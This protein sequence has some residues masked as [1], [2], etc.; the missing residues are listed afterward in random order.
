MGSALERQEGAGTVTFGLFYWNEMTHLS[1][2]YMN[3]ICSA[4]SAERVALFFATRSN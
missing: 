2:S 3:G 1:S 4:V